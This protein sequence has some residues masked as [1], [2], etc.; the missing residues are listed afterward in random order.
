M[1]T[2]ISRIQYIQGEATHQEYYDQFVSQ[3]TINYVVSRIGSETL[4]ASTNKHFNDIPLVRWDNLVLPLANTFKSV[5]WD[6]LTSVLPLAITFKSAGDWATPAGLVC[7]AKAAARQY[8]T[9]NK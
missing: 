9:A 7:V 5:R 8:V 3:A 4:L 6:N 2:T 1:Q